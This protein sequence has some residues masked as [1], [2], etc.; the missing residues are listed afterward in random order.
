MS[1]HITI[2]L[3]DSNFIM[4]LPLK[5]NNTKDNA[6]LQ[7]ILSGDKPLK[8]SAIKSYIE[9]DEA[10]SLLEIIENN[11]KAKI[12]C[13]IACFTFIP[14]I[15]CIELLIAKG[16]PLNQTF[17]NNPF[18]CTAQEY[19][20][21][22]F[23]GISSKI[24]IKARESIYKAIEKGNCRSESKDPLNIIISA[25]SLTTFKKVSKKILISLKRV[26]R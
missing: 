19:L 26:S 16:T 2:Q 4:D 22:H 14:S 18:N 13:L 9:A 5:G 20:D 12:Y 23:N 10:I 25:P 8:I 7:R 21:T 11:I 1:S 3:S 17:E 24:Y 6:Y 15:K